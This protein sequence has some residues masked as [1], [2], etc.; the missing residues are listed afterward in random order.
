MV[1]AR[2]TGKRTLRLVRAIKYNEYATPRLVV[3]FALMEVWSRAIRIWKRCFSSN[4][5]LRQTSMARSMSVA[6]T[7]GED[8]RALLIIFQSDWVIHWRRVVMMALLELS[9]ASARSSGV[10]EVLFK[11]VVEAAGSNAGAVNR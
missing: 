9:C 8:D 10:S 2:S 11:D 3:S 7:V 5:I 1:N 6:E 4:V